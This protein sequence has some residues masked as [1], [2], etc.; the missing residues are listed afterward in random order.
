[1]PLLAGFSAVSGS[2]RIARITPFHRLYPRG[3]HD[4][5]ANAAAD[6]LV[7]ALQGIRLL[8]AAAI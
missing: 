1:M 6:A 4:D 2:Q 8:A 7:F 5:V 3:V